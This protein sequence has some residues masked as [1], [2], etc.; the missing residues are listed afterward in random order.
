MLHRQIFMAGSASSAVES[1]LAVF[2]ETGVVY[3]A[4]WVRS[5]S[6]S[7][8]TALVQVVYQVIYI[9]IV[10]SFFFAPLTLVQAAVDRGFQWT[11]LAMSMLIVRLP[12][13]I[14]IDSR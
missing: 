1:A 4:L 14:R 5:L 12:I 6:S 11:V 2:T 10:G 3:L 13:C 9:A 8:E 7:N